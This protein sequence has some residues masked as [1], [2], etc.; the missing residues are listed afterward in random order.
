MCDWIIENFPDDYENLMYLE[1]FCGAASTLMNKTPS[2]EEGVNDINFTTINILQVIRDQCEEFVTRLKKIKY[3]KNNF[4]LALERGEF[5]DEM[6]AAVNEFV[7]RRM[8]RSGDRK[9]FAASRKEEI[10]WSSIIKMLPSISK[11]LSRVYIFNKPASEVLMAFNTPN[12]LAYVDPPALPDSGEEEVMD[13]DDHIDLADLLRHFK[14][15]VMLSGTP[16][17]LYNR[18]FKDWR[19]VKKKTASKTDCLWVNY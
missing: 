13:L 15:K 11:R 6:D 2:V 3:T 18:I 5:K 16:S 4:D 19:C 9:A 14:G 10:A 7:M 8:S 1:P 12:T 17:P